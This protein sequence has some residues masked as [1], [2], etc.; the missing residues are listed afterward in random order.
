MKEP[1]DILIS[2]DVET[3][4]PYPGRY[5]LLSIGACLV[6]DLESTFYTELQPVSPDVVSDALAISGLTIE[7]L[8]ERGASPPAAMLDF[9]TWLQSVVP[10]GARPVFVGFNAPFDWMFVNDYFHRYLGYNPFGHSALDIK[11]FYA[12]RTGAPWSETSL[13]HIAA[14]YGGVPSLS[15]NALADAIDQANLMVAMLHEQPWN[16]DRRHTHLA[17]EMEQ[18]DEL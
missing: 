15:H 13:R 4:G 8:L 18:L 17:P 16:Q 3:A 6:S 11:A 5:S 2:V 9:A 14:R 7:G 12:G 10:E 1:T